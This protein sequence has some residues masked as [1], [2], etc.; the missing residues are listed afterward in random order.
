MTEPQLLTTDQS[1]LYR[2]PARKAYLRER[3]GASGAAWFE[4]DLGSVRDKAGLLRVLAHA[5]A[6]PETF[7]ANWDALADSLQDLSWRP[8]RGY[9]LH[10]RHGEGAAQSLGPDWATLLEILGR[11]ADYWRAHGKPFIVLIDGAAQLPTLK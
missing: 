5:G 10:L 8:A 11:T 3:A 7:S 9:V 4:A 2:A 1:G 6:F